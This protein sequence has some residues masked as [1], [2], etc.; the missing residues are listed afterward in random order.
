MPKACRE[1]ESEKYG[2]SSFSGWQKRVNLCNCRLQ[3]RFGPIR[4]ERGKGM[5]K[6][7][8]MKG[9]SMPKSMGN[10]CRIRAPEFPAI[11]MDFVGDNYNGIPNIYFLFS[12]QKKWSWD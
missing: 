1:K 7:P 6:A 4:G 5:E 9:K 2:K 3:T 11:T 12:N 8:E 10:R